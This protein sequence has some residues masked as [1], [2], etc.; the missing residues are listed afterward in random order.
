[1]NFTRRSLLEQNGHFMLI[2]TPQFYTLTNPNQTDGLQKF[3][4]QNANK[5]PSLR[6]SDLSGVALAKTEATEAISLLRF[7][8]ATTSLCSG[9]Q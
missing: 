8:I 1:L 9:L 4:N 5:N 3:K 6:G 2:K 7:E